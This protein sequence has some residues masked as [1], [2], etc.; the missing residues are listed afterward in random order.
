MEFMQ[1]MRLQYRMSRL[2]QRE[3]THWMNAMRLGGSP[4][5]NFDRKPRDGPLAES[6]RSN[7]RLVTTFS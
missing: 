6:S 3:P 1:Q 5:V 7:S 4:S 2:A